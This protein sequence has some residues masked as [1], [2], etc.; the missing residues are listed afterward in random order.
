MA[1]LVW[2]PKY[3]K[4]KNG[5]KFSHHVSIILLQQT[6]RVTT[7]HI[8]NGICIW[9]ILVRQ[10]K[11]QTQMEK[12]INLKNEAMSLKQYLTSYLANCFHVNKQNRSLK[13]K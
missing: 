11:L 5:F 10:R 6:K 2:L 1:S 8:D 9:E 13:L 7:E 4:I 3:K 12:K